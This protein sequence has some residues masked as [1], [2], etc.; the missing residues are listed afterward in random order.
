MLVSLAMGQTVIWERAFDA[1]GNDMACGVAVDYEQNVLVA[2][3]KGS[4]TGHDSVITLKYDPAGN[5]IWARRFGINTFSQGMA[6][7]A[8]KNNN[9]I[10]AGYRQNGTSAFLII[11]Y[12]KNGS[13]RWAKEYLHG[14]WDG[15]CGVAVDNDN[16]IIATGWYST[17]GYWDPLTV[18]FD[19]SGNFI[20]ARTFPTGY[21]SY[22]LRTKT[23][24][25]NNIYAAGFFYPIRP[26]GNC[27]FLTIKYDQ[28]GNY[29]WDRTYTRLF[30]GGPEPFDGAY[31][32]A[33]DKNNNPVVT[34]A[35]VYT[36]YD[37]VTIKYDPNG[38]RLWVRTYDSG[39]NNGGGGVTADRLDNVVVVAANNVTDILKYDPGGTLTWQGSHNFSIS[40]DV[41]A[42]TLNN[43]YAVGDN[44]TDMY[45]VK[46]GV[47]SKIQEKSNSLL[48]PD[49][50]TIHP[51]PFQILTSIS[52]TLKNTSSIVLKVYDQSGRE[53]V[54][55]AKTILSEG[56]HT[57]KWDGRD[58]KGQIVPAGIYYVIY[59][60]GDA[61]VS[62]KL[63]LVR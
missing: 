36:S 19:S 2:G 46:Y 37:C 31:G 14:T 10:V 54:V 28:A 30:P 20:W 43:F 9:V 29:I 3:Y 62:R 52:F 33:V 13:F 8:D 16:N 40:M 56:K 25:T 7:A 49:L 32:I 51:N 22:T 1:G 53:V 42:D 27:G 57:L 11:K 26:P 23:D 21:A 48:V 63:L 58:K 59:K 39:D 55:L 35:L 44:G 6:V 18:K 5:L 61:I 17:G 38:N 34:G 12:D 45:I 50:L 15:A 47:A 41:A 4:G 60:D 24:A